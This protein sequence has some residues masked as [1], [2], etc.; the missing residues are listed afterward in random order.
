MYHIPEI[1]NLFKCKNFEN[2]D[3]IIKFNKILCYSYISL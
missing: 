3:Y 1:K 2:I